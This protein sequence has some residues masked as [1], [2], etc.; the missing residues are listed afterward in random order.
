MHPM[1]GHICIEVFYPQTVT[2]KI[3]KR[4]FEKGKDQLTCPQTSGR[5]K[6]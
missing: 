5:K 4:E 2:T 1:Q 3:Y 6:G